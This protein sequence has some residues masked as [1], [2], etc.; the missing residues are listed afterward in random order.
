M[1]CLRGLLL[2]ITGGSSVSYNA[3]QIVPVVLAKQWGLGLRPSHIWFILLTIIFSIILNRT[4]FGNRVLAVGGKKEA[5]R[6]MGVNTD[7]IKI[8]SFMITA[9]L[10]GLAGITAISRFQLANV[11]FGQGMELEA[12]ASAVIGGTLD[13][14]WSGSRTRS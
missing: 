9:V 13:R 11:T 6:T 12:I 10:A 5:A 7:R 4:V 14:R 8:G 2:G 3:D 1:M